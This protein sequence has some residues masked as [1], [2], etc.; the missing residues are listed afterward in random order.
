VEKYDI[1]PRKTYE[2]PQRLN[3]EDNDNF[4]SFMMGYFDGD[5]SITLQRCKYPRLTIRCHKSWKNN[6]DLWFERLYK[7]YDHTLT[8]KTCAITKDNYARIEINNK[9]L[10]RFLKQKSEKLNLP[11][12]KRKW[13][14]IE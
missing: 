4:L 11:I 5:G 14:K 3:I 1:N 6:L 2:P 10:L 7:L 13:N 8:S 12:M 9:G